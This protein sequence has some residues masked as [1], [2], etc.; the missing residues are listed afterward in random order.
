MLPFA[1]H[2]RS[3]YSVL[4]VNGQGQGQEQD[5]RSM[6]TW[7]HPSLLKELKQEDYLATVGSEDDPIQ[8]DVLDKYTRIPLRAHQVNLLK[9]AL[10]L[11]HTCRVNVSE[12]LNFETKI[13][14]LGDKVGAG[15]SF[16]ILSLCLHQVSP[17][18]VTSRTVKSMGHGLVTTYETEL[19]PSSDENRK[20]TNLLVIPHNLTTQWSEYVSTFFNATVQGAPRVTV[21]NR[22]KMLDDFDRKILQLGDFDLIIITNTMYNRL[23]HIANRM[24]FK[25]QRVIF[26]EVDN[27]QFPACP[28]T[29]AGFYWFV[30]ASFGNLIYPYGFRQ[31]DPARYQHVYRAK[32]LNHSGFVKNIFVGLKEDKRISYALVLKNEDCFVDNTIVLPQPRVRQILC[33]TPASIRMLHGLVPQSVLDSL[34]AGDVD[35]AIQNTCVD[36]RMPEDTIITVLLT[37]WRNQLQL[38][39]PTSDKWRELQ[40]K[41]NTLKARIYEASTCCICIDSID[42]KTITPCCSNAYCFKCIHLWLSRSRAC[43]LCKANVLAHDLYIVDNT[44]PA[45]LLTNE[46]QPNVIDAETGTTPSNDKT[47]NLYQLLKRRLED[48][49]AKILIF[50]SYERTFANMQSVLN[51]LGIQPMYLKGNMYCIRN[52]LEKYKSG[53]QRVMFVNVHHYG[54]GLNLQMTTDIILFHKFDS[55]M[56]KQIVGRAQRFGRTEPLKIWYLLHENELT[57]GFL[58]LADVGSLENLPAYRGLQRP[59]S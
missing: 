25:W 34:N 44:A 1:G 42:R 8:Y 6:L 27:T 57:E 45:N 46:S 31:W 17:N 11:E 16:V 41:I 4:P 13:G 39:D 18:V 36:Q 50:S 2:W 10:M 21:L 35:T 43:P 20:G 12:Y 15:K 58:T 53:E 22:N 24:K 52:M 38:L 56:E 23:V 33:R 40:Q 26:D 32:G 30:T 48:P 3:E 19:P 29:A 37:K 47:E 49:N 55:E 28:E 5:G 7:M 54:S 14:I 59:R 51:L 9:H